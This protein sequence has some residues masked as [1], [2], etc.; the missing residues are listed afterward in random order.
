MGDILALFGFIVLIAG[1]ISL[2]YPLKFLR[3]TNRK[4][5][6]LVLVAGFIIIGIGASSHSTPSVSD[7]VLAK[8]QPASYDELARYPD[9]YDGKG[10]LLHGEVMQK[11]SDTEFLICIS[12]GEFGIWTDQVYVKLKGDAKG[13]RLLEDDIVD[14]VGVAQGEIS[15]K[16]VSGQK[17]SV[18]AIDVYKAEVAIKAGDSLVTEEYLW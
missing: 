14:I 16:S 2:I 6:A 13:T 9:R 3:I 17:I 1:V 8:A 11:I 15:Y 12:K 7:D 5:A 10:V 4:I 18:P